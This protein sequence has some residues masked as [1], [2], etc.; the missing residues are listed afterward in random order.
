MKESILN[1]IEHSI[2]THLPADQPVDAHQI[3]QSPLPNGL[4]H[5]LL[6][7]LERRA[8]LEAEQTF[9]ST[10][11]WFDQSHPDFLALVQEASHRLSSMAR[12]PADEWPRAVRQAAETVL[13][14]L[15][16]PASTLS[17]FAFSGESDSMPAADLRRRTGYFGWYPY[18][19]RAVDAWLARQDLQRVDQV[20]F[21]ATMVHL[22]RTLT[23]DY[24]PEQ[25]MNLL[26]P[27]ANL[28]QFGGI[29]PAGLP[30][31]MVIRFFEAKNQAATAAAI[32]QAA[33]KHDADMITML[34]LQ[35][36][37]T[38]TWSASQQQTVSETEADSSSAAVSMPEEQAPSVEATADTGTEDP[39]NPLPLWKRFQQRTGESAGSTAAPSAPEPG[40]QP[41]WKSFEQR[42]GSEGKKPDNPDP[43]VLDPSAE[44]VGV[45]SRPALRLENQHVVLGT[46]VRKR[47]RFI[48]DL[49]DG[50]EAAFES[51]MDAL[52]EA[53]DWSVASALIA[54]L[55]FRPFRI[56]IYSDTAVDFTNAVEARYSG[57]VT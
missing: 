36:V 11:S 48:R 43:A 51:A 20:Q 7:T 56:D 10:G 27:M 13:D 41:L 40:A 4:S 8:H 49:F 42:S 3:Q 55:V 23:G 54:D 24:T 15:V 52:V 9:L 29:E 33:R 47:D 16:E 14:F 53:P 1:R 21:E 32:A 44:E 46:A 12:F 17:R 38:S 30:V 6:K 39:D 5:F 28:M 50:D 26:G 34:S 25:W 18:M 22:D 19:G 37:I 35:G 57:N 31:G 45:P 2:L